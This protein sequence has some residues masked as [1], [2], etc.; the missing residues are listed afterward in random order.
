[1]VGARMKPRGRKI[2]DVIPTRISQERA[3][4]IG[5]VTISGH[6]L[7]TFGVGKALGY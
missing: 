3:E 6:I 2:L 1:M 7:D 4:Q 5:I